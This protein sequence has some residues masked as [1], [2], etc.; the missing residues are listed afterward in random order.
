MRWIE[1]RNSLRLAGVSGLL[2]L[3]VGLSACATNPATGQRQLALI[4]ESE[5]IRMG[6]ETDEQV[7]AQMGIYGDEELQQYVNDIGQRLAAASER[8]ELPWTFRVV[9][10]PVVNAFA[11]PGG[12]IYVTRGILAHMSSEAEL[13]TVLGHEIGHVT[14]RHSVSQMSK[15]QLLGIGLVAGMV[16]SPEAARY[17]DLLQTGLG[18]LTLKF[19]RDD[20]RQADELGLRYM[21][22]GNYD[23]REMPKVF[24]ML[25]RVSAAASEGGRVPGW[26]ATHPDPG[27][28]E[29]LAR[30]ALSSVDLS[31]DAVVGRDRFMGVIDGMA[32]GINPREGFFRESRFLHPDLAFEFTFP[33]GW[34]KANQKQRVAAMNPDENVLLQLTLAEQESPS[35]ALAEFL[36]QEGIN[37]GQRWSEQLNGLPAEGAAF[38]AELQSQGGTSRRILGRVGFVA[39]DGNVYQL[40]AYGLESPFRAADGEVVTWMRSFKKLTDRRAL[41]AQPHRIDIVNLRSDS[42]I[43]GVQSSAPSSVDEEELALING[44]ATTET[45]PAGFAFKRVVGEEW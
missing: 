17:A 22:R 23:P 14:A 21:L 3:V 7:V 20:E 44:V 10:D 13:A 32:Y 25:G 2:A 30:T 11:L 37:T 41:A 15:Q 27:S 26:L 9:D 45:M 16:A 39:Y 28:R 34:Q 5:E 36:R 35:S 12:Y 4:S 40:L 19:S 38:S 29:E 33:A 8:P 18:L 1:N 42:T 43:A 6:Q 31:A 24:A